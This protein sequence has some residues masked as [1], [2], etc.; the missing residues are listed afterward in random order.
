MAASSNKPIQ[1]E[2]R[3][4]LFLDILGFKEVVEQSAQPKST[5]SMGSK[6]IHPEG[7]YFSLKQVASTLNYRSSLASVTGRLK[8]SSRVMTQFS[9]SVVVSYRA[10]EEG[11]LAT[12][13]YDVLHLQLALVQRGLLIRGAIT[14]GLLHHDEDFVFGPAL[15]EAAELEKVAMYPRVIVDRDLL[16]AAGISTAQ[17]VKSGESALRTTASL[18]AQDLDGLFYVDYFAVRPE[19]FSDEWSDLSEYLIDLRE[20]IKGLAAKRQPSLRMKH[21]WLRQKFNQIAEP[22]EKSKFT[23]FGTY[24]VPADEEDHI[25]NVMPFR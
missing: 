18:V 25:F 17:I 24:R 16:T 20:V 4:C 15:N 8:P 2:D 14:Q 19:D 23:S 11:G 5:A 9:D 21:S 13:L 6:R 1:Y 10:G 12:M 22:L 7:I 3:Y